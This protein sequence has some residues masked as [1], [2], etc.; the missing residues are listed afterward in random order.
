MVQSDNTYIHVVKD[1]RISEILGD[2][3]DPA[4]NIEVPQF[5]EREVRCLWDEAAAEALGWDSAELARLRLRLHQEPHVQRMGYG[6]YG[7]E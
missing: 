2:C 5:R 4:K 6:Q 3:W 1:A 7:A